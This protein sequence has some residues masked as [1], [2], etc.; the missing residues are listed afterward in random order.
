MLLILYCRPGF[1]K[2]CATEIKIHA[3]NIGIAGFCR[4]APG[5]AFVEFDYPENDHETLKRH[6]SFRSLIFCRQLLF[7][8]P[9]VEFVDDDRATPIVNQLLKYTRTLAKEKLYSNLL[10]ETPDTNEGKTLQRFC[11]KFLH[12]MANLLK[13]E[14]FKRIY[15]DMKRAKLHILFPS[16]DSAY[17]GVSYSDNASP[18]YMG[19]PRLKAPKEAPSRSTLKLEEAFITFLGEKRTQD[20]LTE[21]MVAVDLGAA[22]GGWSYQMVKRGIFVT[23]IDNGSMDKTLLASGMLEHLKQDAFAYQPR[24]KVDWLI[25]DIV[26]KPTKVAQLTAKWFKNGWCK[27][28]IVNL[29]LPMKKRYE[30]TQK[31]LKKIVEEGELDLTKDQI[32]CRQLFHDREEVTL[33][34]HKGL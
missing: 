28:A 26:D 32:V 4:T 18:W 8:A 14:G 15:S 11:K 30:E 24:R 23:A 5:S 29:K 10:I 12:P 19:I 13:K 2:E 6:L 17:I 16:Y 1:E 9:K 22:P 25:C 31:C 34:V 3:E 27:M 20:L 21:G 7:C 33:F